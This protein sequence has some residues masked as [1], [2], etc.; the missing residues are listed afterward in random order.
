MNR[1]DG[2][3]ALGVVEPAPRLHYLDEGDL[4]RRRYALT[5]T[6]PALRD[7]EIVSVACYQWLFREYI[8]GR[9]TALNPPHCGPS[10]WPPSSPRPNNHVLR[11]WLRCDSTGP[12]REMDTAMRQVITLFCRAHSR[13]DARSRSPGSFRTTRRSSL[14][15][16][17]DDLS[18]RVARREHH[19][20]ALVAEDGRQRHG[21]PL[22]SRGDVGVADPDG[23]HLDKYLIGAGSVEG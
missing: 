22:V 18:Y 11:C 1:H 17:R 19:A 14:P 16:H 12:V 9:T 10:S 4:A 8:V 23:R 7:R 21:H 15:G 5:S 13:Q 2:E 3:P 20:R 6:V